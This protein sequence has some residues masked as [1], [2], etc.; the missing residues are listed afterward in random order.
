MSFQ[1]RSF[2]SRQLADDGSLKMAVE[3]SAVAEVRKQSHKQKDKTK[4]VRL[5]TEG[6]KLAVEEL[7]SKLLRLTRAKKEKPDV[8]RTFR[9]E[10]VK[11][12]TLIQSMSTQEFAKCDAE[13][14]TALMHIIPSTLRGQRYM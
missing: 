2:K 6:K 4:R 12:W 9:E 7:F 1:S 11:E 5:P 13:A 14:K 3:T 10:R 8:E